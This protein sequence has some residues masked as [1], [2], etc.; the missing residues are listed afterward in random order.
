MKI[1]QLCE[2]NESGVIIIK[3]PEI[4]KKNTQLLVIIDDS[5]NANKMEQMKKAAN[6]PLFLADIN[7][8]TN[9]FEFTD[10]EL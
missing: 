2:V 1:K 8:I 5:F 9:D 3:I 6:D 7:E 10:S 4:F